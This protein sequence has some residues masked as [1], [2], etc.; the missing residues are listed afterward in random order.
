MI[1]A[2][3]KSLAL[4]Y[5]PDTNRSADATTKMQDINRAYEII[6]D[7]VQ[8]SHW[9]QE[10][11]PRKNAAPSADDLK[12]KAEEELKR[13]KAYAEEAELRRKQKEAERR[14]AYE[15]IIREKARA[16]AE[17][18][19]KQEEER[20]KAYEDLMR[21]KAR[22]EE[23]QR[24]KQ[25]EELRKAN[26]ELA[27]E[28]ARAEEEQRRQQKEAERRRA[29]E[30][31]LRVKARD[32]EEKRRKQQEIEFRKASEELMREKKRAEE[33]KRRKEKE[34][35]RRIANEEQLREKA[36]TE[37]EQ[38]RKQR[39]KEDQKA[40]EKLIRERSRA[41]E[42]LRRRLQEE[43]RR[44][45]NEELAREK[46]L[47]KEEQRR[48]QLE[49]ENQKAGEKLLRE[50]VRAEDQLRRKQQ[51]EERLKANEELAREKTLAKEEQ[52]RKQLER[53]NREASERKLREKARAEEQLRQKKE[54][55]ERRKAN[56]ELLREKRRIET[57]QRRKQQ[58][59]SEFQRREKLRQQQAHLK[60]G[61][62]K[63]AERVRKNKWV[64]TIRKKSRNIG[65]IGPVVSIAALGSLFLLINFFSTKANN[66]SILTTTGS[67]EIK[68]V[69]YQ[70]AGISVTS[71]QP[72]VTPARPAHLHSS[73]T[74]QQMAEREIEFRKFVD[75]LNRGKYISTTIGRYQYLGTG[76]MILTGPYKYNI[77]PTG[78]SFQPVS[79]FIIRGTI[80]WEAP[81]GSDG[82]CGF[83]VA[84][85]VDNQFSGNAMIADIDTHNSISLVEMKQGE[86]VSGIK[87]NLLVQI[88]GPDE[89]GS[90]KNEAW[91]HNTEKE[92]TIIVFNNK[93]FVFVDGVEKIAK[94]LNEGYEGVPLPMVTARSPDFFKCAFKDVEL[95]SIQ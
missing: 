71:L 76:E 93:Y 41:E 78:G 77:I 31:Q 7:E 94:A 72:M 11:D 40:G 33:E 92:L 52:R 14:K 49:R 48:K 74:L 3:Y 82:N 84:K 17:L 59:L 37:E 58:E 39:E 9:D 69:V 6:G 75:E 32:E 44:K 60:E 13:Q 29:Y 4:K 42:E 18:R 22:A 5:H 46:T 2:A 86:D 53:K 8:R 81:M 67:R 10:H 88:N 70:S 28:K 47:A 57:E 62:D 80:S 15:D 38:R 95:F 24:R 64:N 12:K 26:E 50:K 87:P 45:A 19:R 43:E 73:L 25:E 66:G 30:E 36:R 35:E 20:R 54:E 91:R 79:A 65:W 56:E 21:E 51:E 90:Y 83:A 34:E 55:A 85:I 27:R 16:E 89:N 63:L 68:P 1:N 61:Y 23:E